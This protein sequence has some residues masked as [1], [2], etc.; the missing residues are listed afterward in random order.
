MAYHIYPVSDYREHTLE[1]TTCDCRPSVQF[2]NGEMLVVHN[3]YDGREHK[4][5]KGI[6]AYGKETHKHYEGDDLGKQSIIYHTYLNYTAK[7]RQP[8]SL[9]QVLEIRL[10]YSNKI[11]KHEETGKEELDYSPEY[12]KREIAGCDLLLKLLADG[13]AY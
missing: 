2:E 12:C 10:T 1:G 11:K 13:K 5:L 4:E 6:E 7:N 3:S 8:F 9:D